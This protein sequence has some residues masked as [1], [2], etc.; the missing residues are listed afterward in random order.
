[1]PQSRKRVSTLYRGHEITVGYMHHPEG[2]VARVR[3]D[4]GDWQ[5]DNDIIRCTYYEACFA[6]LALARRLIDKQ[7]ASNARP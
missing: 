4:D 7:S 2:I 3:I 1:M 5:Y 6:G